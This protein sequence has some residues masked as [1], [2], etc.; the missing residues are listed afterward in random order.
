MTAVGESIKRVEDERFLTGRGCYVGDITRDGQVWTRV[1]RSSV[2]HGILKAVHLEKARACPGVVAAFSAADLPQLDSLRVPIRLSCPPNGMPAAQPLLALDRVRYVGEPIAL[3]VGLD[4][5]SAEDAAATVQVEIDELPPVLD[6]IAATEAGAALLHDALGSNIVGTY[7]F[8]HGESIETL[9]D[10]AD[11]VISERLRMHRHSSVPLET[12]G[13]IAEVDGEGRL[14]VWGPTKVKHHNRV[15]LSDLIGLPV[16]RIRFIEPDV[17]GSFGARGE[18]YPEDFLIPWLAIELGRPVKWIE[19][20]AENLVAMNHSREHI[21]D[22][23]VAALADGTLLA[24]RSRDFCDMG[25]YLRTTGMKVT[26]ICGRHLAGPYRWAGFAVT[27]SGVMTNKTP[28]GTYRGPGESE[29]TFARERMLDLL[30]IEV[31]MDPADLR[32]RNLITPEDLPYRLEFGVPFEPV[33]HESGDYRGQFQALLDHVGYDELRNRVGTRRQNGELSGIGLACFINEGAYGPFEWARIVAEPDRTFVGYVGAAS[34]GQGVQTAL[35]QILADALDVPFERVR[36]EHHDTDS[37]LDGVG[38]WADRT[39]AMAGSALLLAARKLQG[40]ARQAGAAALGVAEDTVDVTRDEV[41]VAGGESALTFAELGCSATTRFE[42]PGMAFSFGASLSTV[43]VE[44]ETGR[45]TVE[46]Y[47]GAYDVGLA[48]NPMLVRGQLDGAAAQGIA[49]ALFEQFSYDSDGQPLSASFADYVIPTC[50]EIP[51]VESLIFEFHAP[52]NP[53]GVKGAGNPGIV[54]T[55]AA[56]A[57]AVA[58]AIGAGGA[59]V[60]TLP[61]RPPLVYSLL[62]GREATVVGGRHVD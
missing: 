3:V 51:E 24:F 11:F 34:Y 16:E 23:E 20:R 60:T 40:A 38:S 49:G 45:V 61:L 43:A 62:K 4:A 27:T 55:Y 17:G 9:F 35:A 58:N 31:G 57:N 53:L 22:I 44:A 39:T 29:A 12:R 1:V 56:L 37:V 19:D 32:L 8:G 30:A 2:A 14:T 13:L 42:R 6:S 26:E 47:V 5:H 41:H 25:A 59:P 54:G 50:A 10:R 21:F 48:I 36:I 7:E 18:F 15:M 28:I 46:R 52:D 33:T